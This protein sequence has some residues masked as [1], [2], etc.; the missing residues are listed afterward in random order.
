MNA[1]AQAEIL[2]FTGVR[3]ERDT[4]PMPPMPFE[5]L[6]IL[7]KS[8]ISNIP[9]QRVSQLPLHLRLRV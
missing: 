2:I 6:S 7:K 3:Y 8:S 9:P 5:N 4:Q 1:P